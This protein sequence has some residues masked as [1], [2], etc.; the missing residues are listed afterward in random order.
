[1]DWQQQYSPETTVGLKQRL[2]LQGKKAWQPHHNIVN[3]VL[4][5]LKSYLADILAPLNSDFSTNQK[6]GKLILTHP[7]HTWLRK[8]ASNQDSPKH[9]PML[10]PLF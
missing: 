1:M 3:G 10:E 4:N 7:N 9:L 5:T 6:N 2:I 8:N